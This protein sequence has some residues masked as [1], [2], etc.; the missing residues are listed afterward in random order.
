MKL[1]LKAGHHHRYYAP[2]WVPVTEKIAGL[3]NDWQELIEAGHG[4]GTIACQ[5]VTLPAQVV[6]TPEGK[7]V[8][9]IVP[10]MEA[11]S[12]KTC[13]FVSGKVD[14]PGVRLIDR[15]GRLELRIQDRWFTEYVFEGYAKP[16][17]GP[18]SAPGVDASITRLDLETREHP[19]QRS[20][21]F[22]HGDVNGVDCWNEPAERHGKEIHKAFSHRTDG[23]VVGFFASE[24]TWTDFHGQPLVDDHRSMALYNLWEGHRVMDLSITLKANY[25]PV[26][27]GATKEAGPLGIRVAPEMTVKNG[28]KI[29]NAY[30][31][32]NEQECWGKRSPWCDYSGTVEGHPVGIAIFDHVDNEDHPT[33]WHVRDYGLFAGNNFHFLGQRRLESGE[34]VTYRYRVLFHAGDCDL[35]RVA[36][37]Y[38]DYA[39][40]IRV[41]FSS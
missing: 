31:A 2:V 1:L 5:D 10:W 40:P 38:H 32:I 14:M 17:W 36:A 8:V 13:E 35:A 12:E 15:A 7:F 22:S 33:F 39:N 21:W 23:A 30:G 26:T 19:H 3:P 24:N 29:T 20:L 18:I 28:G 9:F 16:F 4:T 34:T 27:L 6:S 37:R 11:G 41:E 25:G